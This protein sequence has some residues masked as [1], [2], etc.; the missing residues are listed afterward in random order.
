MEVEPRPLAVGE[1]LRERGE[2]GSHH[3]LVRE[4]G[5]HAGPHRLAEVLDR[6]AEDLQ[7]RPAPVKR[8]PAPPDH[9]PQGARRRPRLAAG[10][11]RVE[12][13]DAAIAEQGTEPFAHGRRNGRGVDVDLAL[14]PALKD[15]P[16]T[17]DDILDTL[18][19]GQA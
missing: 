10:D 11:R 6:A 3:D 8:A 2:M 12:H 19:G 7:H 9:N 15:T 14:A 13:V 18:P 1:R 5:V 16:R 17:G 4:L